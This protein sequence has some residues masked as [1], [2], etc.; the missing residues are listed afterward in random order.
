MKTPRQSYH[1]PIW[2][3]PHSIKCAPSWLER[4]WPLHKMFFPAEFWLQLIL[5]N[6][7]INVGLIKDP[8]RKGTFWAALQY[9]TTNKVQVFINQT[10]NPKQM[11]HKYEI[12]VSKNSRFMKYLWTELKFV[13]SWWL[14]HEYE[15]AKFKI[16]N[17][18]VFTTVSFHELFC[19]RYM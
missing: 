3:V 10:N 8:C 12:D 16:I 7:T 1:P 18:E 19:F 5:L 6:N 9:Y 11:C 15:M 2:L 17:N 13:S 4:T 14:V